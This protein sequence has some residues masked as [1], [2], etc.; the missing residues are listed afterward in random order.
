[1]EETPAVRVQSRSVW[2]PPAEDDGADEQYSYKSEPK[3]AY[4]E[5]EAGYDDEP[6]SKYSDEDLARLLGDMDD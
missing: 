1:M 5:D 6:K 2:Q 3:E 4:Y